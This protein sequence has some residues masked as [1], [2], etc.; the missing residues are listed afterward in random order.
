VDTASSVSGRSSLDQLADAYPLVSGRYQTQ[1]GVKMSSHLAIVVAN[2]K[3]SIHFA[4]RLANTAL[5]PRVQ[6]VLVRRQ[7]P[8]APLTPSSGDWQT[9]IYKPRADLRWRSL[10]ASNLPFLGEY[11]FK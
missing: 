2:L 6:V 10:S 9:T 5:S 4:V 1:S 8:S 11:S 3:S 7:V